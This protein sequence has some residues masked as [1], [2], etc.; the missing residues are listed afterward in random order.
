M[1]GRLSVTKFPIV[2]RWR[3]P[4]RREPVIVKDLYHLDERSLLPT[5]IESFSANA[6]DV[7]SGGNAELRTLLKLAKRF[8]AIDLDGN[9]LDELWGIDL[10]GH[11]T[12]LTLEGGAAGSGS[13]WRVDGSW[14]VADPVQIAVRDANGDGAPDLVS[15]D[16]ALVVT[17]ASDGAGRVHEFA[18]PAAAAVCAWIQLDGDPERELLCSAEAG[19]TAA[20]LS[21]Y[22][23]NFETDELS[24]RAAP[25]VETSERFVVGDFDGNGVD[26]LATLGEQLTIAFGTPAL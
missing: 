7:S 20:A 13:S 21:A 6:G 12:Q 5:Q 17:G 9:G 8:V 10:L 24:P 16:S 1:S 25:E 19:E 2:G 11:L 14:S 23:A 26:D 15:L 18:L 22:D 4:E 3:S